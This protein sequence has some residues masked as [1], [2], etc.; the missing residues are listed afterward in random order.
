MALSSS[1]IQATNIVL[2]LAGFASDTKRFA[3]FSGNTEV[4]TGLEVARVSFS[5]SAKLFEH[6]IETGSVITDHEIFDPCSINIQ[7]YI[8]G[9]DTSTLQTLENYYLSGTELKIRAGNKIVNKT[10][11]SSKPFELSSDVFDK[12]LYNIA[13]REIMEVTPSYVG[14]SKAASAANASSV[15]SGVKQAKETSKPQSWLDSLLR[16][17]R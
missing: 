5:D 13:F 16:G 8:S 14:M 15:N 12:T 6:P 3:V 10:V 4:L 17:D 7:A 9:T 1:I 2:T 11:I